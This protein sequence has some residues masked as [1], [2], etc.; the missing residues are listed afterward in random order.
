M[1]KINF[2]P[3]DY[4][5]NSESHRTNLLYLVLLAIVMAVLGSSFM[6]IKVRQR[7][8]ASDERLVSTKIAKAKEAI[9][10]FE[11]LQIKRK[12]MMKTALTTAGL[13]EPIPRSVLLA[14]LTN[15]LPD[16]VSLLQLKMIQKAPKQAQL[17]RPASKY[18]SLQGEKQPASIQPELSQEKLLET[19]IDIE[20]IAPSDLQVAAYIE[21]LISSTLLDNVTLVES[22]QSKVGDSSFRQFKLKAMLRNDVHLTCDDIEKIKTRGRHALM[23]F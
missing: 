7:S 10:Q 13:L 9:K 22:K 23:N 12:K 3:D 2:V 15:D 1:L 20:G 21:Q 4:I 5:Q 11:E 19:C 8:I 16:G 17:S 18:E 6:I 14:S